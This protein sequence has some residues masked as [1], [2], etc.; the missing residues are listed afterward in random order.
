MRELEKLGFGFGH[1][2]DLERKIKKSCGGN[3]QSLSFEIVIVTV[4]SGDLVR[5]NRARVD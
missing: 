2:C 5:Y 1:W 3:N 4:N